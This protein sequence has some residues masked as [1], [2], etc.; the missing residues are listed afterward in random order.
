MDPLTPIV[1]GVLTK[2]A[3]DHGA[4]ILKKAGQA[5]ADAAGKVFN[6]VMNKLKGDPR[7]GWIAEQFAKDPEAYK[8]PVTDAVEEQIKADPNFAAEMKALIESFDK[9]QQAAG[10]TIVNTG[11]GAVATQGGVAA[12]AGGMAVGGNVSGGIVMGNNNQVTNTNRNGGVDISPSGG[13]VNITGD[14]VGRDKKTG[15]K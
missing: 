3:T 15:N 6:G 11:S 14:I 5:T 7:F 2:F 4:D 10:V 8:A 12:G 9:A 13:T 1:I